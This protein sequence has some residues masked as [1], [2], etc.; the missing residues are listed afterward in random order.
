M[1]HVTFVTKVT[2]VIVATYVTSFTLVTLVIHVTFATCRR[3]T[4]LIVIIQIFPLSDLWV[5]I[6]PLQQEKCI[7]NRG[8]LSNKG[9]M[10][11]ET[12]KNNRVNRGNMSK[13]GNKCK[14]ETKV[15]RVTE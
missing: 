11:K 15:T 2:F 3:G 8:N 10:C 5:A 7:G 12:Y 13:I 14:R 1:T 4:K 9:N 6:L